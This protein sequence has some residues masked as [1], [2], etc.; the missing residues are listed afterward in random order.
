MSRGRPGAAARYPQPAGTASKKPAREAAARSLRLETGNLLATRRGAEN[1][2][3]A[4][5]FREQAGQTSAR[6]GRRR[7]RHIAQ[8]L[9]AAVTLDRGEVVRNQPTRTF[10]CDLDI[11][12]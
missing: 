8:E 5:L 6:L 1:S 7:G 2:L 10:D 4:H 12:L 9:I 11:A 3:N